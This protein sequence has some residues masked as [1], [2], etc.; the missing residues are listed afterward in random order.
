MT[1]SFSK[2][3]LRGVNYHDSYRRLLHSSKSTMFNKV[4]SL[5]RIKW[6]SENNLDIFIMAAVYYIH[7]NYRVLHPVARNINCK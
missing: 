2:P 3:L 7:L 5:W 1:L 6:R 4:R